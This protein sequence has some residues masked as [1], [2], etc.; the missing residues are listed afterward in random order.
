MLKHSSENGYIFNTEW[1]TDKNT[2]FVR[3]STSKENVTEIYVLNNLDR[4]LYYDHAAN[5][6]AYHLTYNVTIFKNSK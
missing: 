6:R 4:D 1:Q 2:M 5:T 3:A